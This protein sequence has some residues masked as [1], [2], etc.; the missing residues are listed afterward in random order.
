MPKGK[1]PWMELEKKLTK[2]TNISSS[3][4]S[5]EIYARINYINSFEPDFIATGNGGFNDYLVLG[6]KDKNLFVLEN[7]LPKNATY[8][9]KKDWKEITKLSKAEILA[10]NLQEARL[11][12]SI[13]WKNN[14]KNELGE[15]NN[16][17]ICKK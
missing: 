15:L 1:M 12:H 16:N 13:N 14:I 5:K 11:I 7:R 10:E 9:F 3:K 2:T 6:F 8:I 4:N 17:E